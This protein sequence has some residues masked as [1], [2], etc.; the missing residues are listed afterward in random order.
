MRLYLLASVLA[1]DAAGSFLSIIL[2]YSSLFL[3]MSLYLHFFIFVLALLLDGLMIVAQSLCLLSPDPN[4]PTSSA[5]LT[6]YVS[7]HG[8]QDATF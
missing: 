7:L 8:R 1:D 4:V 3:L 5:I 6:S 2:K